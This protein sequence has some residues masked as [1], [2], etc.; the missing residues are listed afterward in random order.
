MA[1]QKS[2]DDLLI[3]GAA[4]RAGNR[5]SPHPGAPDQPNIKAQGEG[6]G[7]PKH[8][9]PA[10]LHPGTIDAQREQGGR[11]HPTCGIP[12]RQPIDANPG[13]AK[14]TKPADLHGGMREH[15]GARHDPIMADRV[16]GEALVSGSAILPGE[17]YTTASDKRR[18]K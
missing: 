13:N 14:R 4:Q 17:P 15:T 3:P 9:G 1:A 2:L 11:G 6:V 10:A 7:L 16:H 12:P 8:R 18:R 5:S